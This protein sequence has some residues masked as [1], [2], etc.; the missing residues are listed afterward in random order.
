MGRFGYDYA[1][2]THGLVHGVGPTCGYT[3]YSDGSTVYT[4]PFVPCDQ[5]YIGD[6]VHTVGGQN[7][8]M[9][10]FSL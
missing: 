8:I 3:L 10:D 7:L 5:L 2:D 1:Y 9:G 4:I 6:E